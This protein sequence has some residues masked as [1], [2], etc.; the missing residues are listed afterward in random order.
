MGV[1]MK[2]TGREIWDGEEVFR[3][4]QMGGFTKV[5]SSITTEMESASWVGQRVKNMKDFVVHHKVVLTISHNYP[6]TSTI[7]QT[8]TQICAP[9]RILRPVIGVFYQVTVNTLYTKW[10]L[11]QRLPRML[12]IPAKKS[13][14][15]NWMRLKIWRNWK[16]FVGQI[17][18]LR[19]RK[20]Y[21]IFQLITLIVL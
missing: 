1:S 6:L 21:N 2:V 7:R 11:T 4:G 5:N 14:E 9:Q 20:N 3:A 16:I 17:L 8:V 13:Q 18:T 19:P 10:R 15:H 12:K